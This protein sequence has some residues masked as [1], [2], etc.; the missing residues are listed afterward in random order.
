MCCCATNR[1]AWTPSG[2]YQCKEYQLY[3]M[4][5]PEITELQQYTIKNDLIQLDKF[6]VEQNLLKFR[7]EME[8]LKIVE[9]IKHTRVVTLIMCE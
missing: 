5:K 1:L 3:H 8:S 4:I 7:S 9:S 6:S 2:S